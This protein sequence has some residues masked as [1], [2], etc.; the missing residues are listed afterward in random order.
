MFTC[1][2]RAVKLIV[3]DFNFNFESQQLQK[4]NNRGKMIAEPYYSM[5][6]RDCLISSCVM[7]P[8]RTLPPD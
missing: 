5:F 4:Q 2:R 7:N 3:I 6:Y 1:N 8:Q